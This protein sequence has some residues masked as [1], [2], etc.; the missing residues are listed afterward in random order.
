VEAVAG[1]NWRGKTLRMVTRA[2]I[3]S[4]MSARMNAATPSPGGERVGGE[5]EVPQA[6]QDHRHDQ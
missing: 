2:M 3:A 6:V 1:V 4:T 5:P